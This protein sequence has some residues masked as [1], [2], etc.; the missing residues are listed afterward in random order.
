MFTTGSKLLIGSAVV[1]AIAAV[2]YG[3]TQEG[4][5][6]TIGLV[7]AAL[8]LAF[9][10]GVDLAVRDATVPAE[11]AAA[12]ATAPAASRAPSSSVWPLVGALGAIAVGVG[13]VTVQPLVLIGIALLIAA[14]AEWTVQAWSER[15]SADHDFNEEIREHVASPLELPIL[16]AVGAGALVYFFSRVMLNLDKAGTV[17][18]FAM[19]ATLLLIV[20]GLLA[21]RRG[22]RN[23]VVFGMCALV[24]VALIAGGAVAALAGEREM[25]EHETTGDLA[26]RGECGPEETEADEDASQTVSAK[27]NVAAQIVLEGDAL[28]FDQPGYDGPGAI[29]TLPRSTPLNLLFRNETADA[30]RLVISDLPVGDGTEVVTLCTALVEDGGVQ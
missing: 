22:V 12:V 25:H 29:L 15:A 13:F 8:A 19:I 10:A 3:V 2:V 23:G 6:G 16:A 20:A 14:A 17:F 21:T 26:Q 28:S 30:R 18:A 11:D 5:L 24:A 4:A 27:S 1:A 7:S 9:L